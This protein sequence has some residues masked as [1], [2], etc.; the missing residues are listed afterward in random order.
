MNV[1]AIDTATDSPGVALSVGGRIA[2]RRIGWR[3]AF[4]ETAPAIESL[5]AEA[6][7]ER[8]DLEAVAVPAGPGSFTGLRVG[9]AFALGLC[10]GSGVPLHAVPTL[11]AVAE[12]Y[13]G[14]EDG[15]V[16]ASIDA[17]RGRRFAAL[18]ERRDGGWRRLAGPVDA[19]PEGVAELAG[20]ARVVAPPE[21]G[22]EPAVAVA[23]AALVTR[24]PA[25]RRLTSPGELS[26]V[27]ARPGVEPP[28]GPS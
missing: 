28:A 10:R 2:S 5:L 26:L 15:R 20:G 8:G 3:S 9:A 7:L 12:A 6:G 18:Y 14:P 1:L 23:I 24:E 21:A 17:R 19:G 16:C 22:G 27:Y 4:V 11:E 25:R 13:A